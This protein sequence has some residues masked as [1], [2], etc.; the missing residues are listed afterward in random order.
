MIRTVYKVA[1]VLSMFMLV[2][3]FTSYKGI[4]K[5]QT[6][7]FNAWSELDESLQQRADLIPMVVDT[8]TN[9]MH[10]DAATI[11]SAHDARIKAKSVY[12][13]I[14]QLSD[15]EQVQKYTLAQQEVQDSLAKLLAVGQTNAELKADQYFITLQ[16]QLEGLENR[17][18]VSR[19]QIA[20]VTNQ[21]NSSIHK[22]P[23]TVVNKLFLHL[24]K[25]EFF[26]A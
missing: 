14:S 22:F 1:I 6:V 17:I 20:A 10:L 24:D 23:G 13:D 16:Y 4:L 15:I 9:Q 8:V 5:S 11:E 18:N 19:E 21:F 26:N 3:G 7:V 25:K 2:T 12:L